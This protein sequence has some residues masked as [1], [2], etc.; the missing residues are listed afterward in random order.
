MAE[1]RSLLSLIARGYAAGRADA[2]TEALRFIL[3]RRQSARVA[4]SELLGDNGKPL[5]IASFSTQLLVDG[6]Y[7]DMI[8]FDEQGAR[9]AFIECKFWANL[10]KRQ[11]V[12]YWRQLPGQPTGRAPVPGAG[13]SR[14]PLRLPVG[15]NRGTVGKRRPRVGVGP[16]R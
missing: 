12:D 13:E 5:P 16:C 3:S 15:R 4:L 6:A 11:P 8:C 14:R 7:P 10:T 1:A 2:A 9:V